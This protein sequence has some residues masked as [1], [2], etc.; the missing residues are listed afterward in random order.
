MAMETEMPL[1]GQHVDLAM[2]GSFAD[3]SSQAPF[4]H[5]LAGKP[6]PG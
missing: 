2:D 6:S 3:F 4:D 5:T 1:F